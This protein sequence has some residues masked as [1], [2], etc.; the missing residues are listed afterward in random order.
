MD[1]HVIINREDIQGGLRYSVTVLVK[2][3]NELCQGHNHGGWIIGV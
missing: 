2:R 3:K 1:I